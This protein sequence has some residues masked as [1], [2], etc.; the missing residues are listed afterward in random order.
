[1]SARGAREKAAA[2]AAAAA[3]RGMPA[4]DAQVGY[5]QRLQYVSGDQ[6]QHAAQLRKHQHSVALC[7][8]CLA[9]VLRQPYPQLVQNVPAWAR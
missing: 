6:V 2:A 9:P 5:A 4:I 7:L 3:E 1:M 8:L